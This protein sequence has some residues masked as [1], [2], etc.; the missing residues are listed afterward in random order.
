[1]TAPAAGNRA[2]DRAQG[3][4]PRSAVREERDE[5]EKGRK[6]KNEMHFDRW[7]REIVNRRWVEWL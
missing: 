1:V 6:E 3:A 4:A 2:R 7:E 5:I